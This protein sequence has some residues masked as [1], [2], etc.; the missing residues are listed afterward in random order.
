MSASREDMPYHDRLRLL[1]RELTALEVPP[2]DGLADER[3]PGQFAFAAEEL[4]GTGVDR[5]MNGSRGRRDG[6]DLGL[7]PAIGLRSAVAD[8]CELIDEMLSTGLHDWWPGAEPEVLIVSL[9]PHRTG[10]G[11]RSSHGRSTPSRGR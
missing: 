5:L 2:A 4:H 1:R 6:P 3:D 10:C 7:L 9:V 8:A 11:S